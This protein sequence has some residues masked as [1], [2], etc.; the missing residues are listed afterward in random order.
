MRSLAMIGFCVLTFG[1][2]QGPANAA[3]ILKSEPGP[4]EL[5]Y[6]MRVLVDDGSCPTGQI[7][8]VLAGRD[9]DGKGPQRTR[10][11]VSRR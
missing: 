6:G 8:E 3:R 7:K 10:R 5:R 2:W 4:G 9:V 11:C 1:A